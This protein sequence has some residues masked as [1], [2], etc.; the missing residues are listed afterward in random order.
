MKLFSITLSRTQVHSIH[1]SPFIF[2]LIFNSILYRLMI[3]MNIVYEVDI[4]H[5]VPIPWMLTPQSHKY[6]YIFLLNSSTRLSLWILI[7][8]YSKIIHSHGIVATNSLLYRPYA[9]TLF[10]FFSRYAH[11]YI[12]TPLFQPRWLTSYVS[13]LKASWFIYKCSTLFPLTASSLVGLATPQQY[14]TEYLGFP[15]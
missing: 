4:L 15:I 14:V 9:H 11:L 1:P 13:H 5:V 3:S 8:R 7:L 6:M 2:P 12:C 10:D